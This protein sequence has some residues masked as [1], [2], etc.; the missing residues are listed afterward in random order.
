M[1][2]ISE[3]M[4]TRYLEVWFES[5][6]RRVR[7]LGLYELGFLKEAEEQRK[8]ACLCELY[9]RRHY[10]RFLERVGHEELDD[11]VEFVNEWINVEQ[12]VQPQ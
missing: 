1:I 10:K 8:A 9:C 11:T 3:Q 12:K 6:Q 7:A 5:A 4:R 2:A